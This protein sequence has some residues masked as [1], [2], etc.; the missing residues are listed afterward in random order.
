M[1]KRN[2]PALLEKMLIPKRNATKIYMKNPQTGIYPASID[3]L[4]GIY[5]GLSQNV[6]NMNPARFKRHLLKN[7]IKYTFS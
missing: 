5:N 3:R 4:V 2:C 6:K 1:Y 7:D